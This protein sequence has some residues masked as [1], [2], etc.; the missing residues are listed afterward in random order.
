MTS[1]LIN[2][3]AICDW[4][5]SCSGITVEFSIG[6]CD[7]L[8]ARSGLK[9]DEVVELQDVIISKSIKCWNLKVCFTISSSK[10]QFDTLYSI[11]QLFASLVEN[12]GTLEAVMI[13]EV[14]ALQ[15][16]RN[17]KGLISC[18]KLVKHWRMT[19][20]N[21]WGSNDRR[22]EADDQSIFCR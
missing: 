15:A 7:W 22:R 11:R 6:F 13:D 18:K 3:R 2:A 12:L 8:L 5:H 20:K 1:L 9:I 17:V 21:H 10:L 19:I 16:L 14:S 4:G